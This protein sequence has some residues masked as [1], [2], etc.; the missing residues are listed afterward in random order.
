[1]ADLVPG[2]EYSMRRPDGSTDKVTFIDTKNGKPVVQTTNG[3]K[4]TVAD[5]S[6]Y[7]FTP[8][9]GTKPVTAA[10]KEPVKA[11]P[12][13]KPKTVDEKA[14]EPRIVMDESKLLSP[15]RATSSVDDAPAADDKAVAAVKKYI[16]SM[17]RQ[18]RPDMTRSEI[19]KLVQ[20]TSPS[21]ANNITIYADTVRQLEREGLIVRSDPNTRIERANF[22][23]IRDPK[24]A[25]PKDTPEPGQPRDA[26]ETPATP[27][28]EADAPS[29][30]STPTQR[31]GPQ[32]RRVRNSKNKSAPRTLFSRDGNVSSPEE[33][34]KSEANTNRATARDL[35]EASGVNV[36]SPGEARE[37]AKPPSSERAT[38]D[39]VKNFPAFSQAGILPKPPER[40][41]PDLANR[42]DEVKARIDAGEDLTLDEAMKYIRSGSEA[43]AASRKA[44][45]DT[46]AATG[47]SGGSGRAT[48]DD[49]KA[50]FV[51][52]AQELGL[53]PEAA[54]SM[55][56]ESVAK[57]V[58]R[59]AAADGSAGMSL[60]ALLNGGTTNTPAPSTQ[61]QAPAGRQPFDT[62]DF[63]RTGDDSGRPAPRSGDSMFTHSK[64]GGATPPGRGMQETLMAIA[65]EKGVTG[66]AAA[67]FVAGG[68]AAATLAGGA[69]NTAVNGSGQPPSRSMLP[70]DNSPKPPLPSWEE[71]LSTGPQGQPQAPPVP[72]WEAEPPISGLMRDKPTGMPQGSP[73]APQG[74][75][76]PQS[77]PQPQ[78]NG[79]GNYPMPQA[80]PRPEQSNG[81]QPVD[82]VQ[83][84]GGDYPIYRKDSSEAQ[85]FRKAFVNA[86]RS[87]ED[88]FEWQGRMYRANLAD[89]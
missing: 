24:D 11:A 58:A 55:W 49:G 61:P 56:D 83:T 54:E 39:S 76:A 67:L 48:L 62:P 50:N 4:F 18:G 86:L 23:I 70:Q 5:P 43:E 63:Q 44:V 26:I 68:L 6:K 81:S 72:L 7:K 35:R 53:S 52:V 42:W 20:A 71:L 27:V 3:F 9:G 25:R 66:P 30:Q 33:I 10:T 47:G 64:P 12:K 79:Q 65:K 21:A 75:P 51:K 57:N 41:S 2:K 46:P 38:A 77:A 88:V 69:L 36:R 74:Q 22:T 31:R 40:R 82:I 14:P 29:N 37:T 15:L 84:K 73:Q 32:E 85:S 8:V 60:E 28:D 19:L 45:V 34:A 13:A 59:R 1:M 89:G 87:G 78:G 80:N 16:E 17:R